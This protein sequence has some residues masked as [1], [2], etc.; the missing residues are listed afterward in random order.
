MVFTNEISF[1]HYE[2]TNFVD[3]TSEKT[4]D[5]RAWPRPTQVLMEAG[6]ACITMYHIPHSS[7]R[8]EHGTESRKNII[9]RIRN[10]KRQPNIVADNTGVT[11][12]PDRGFMGGWLAFEEGNNPWERS[13]HSMCNMWDEWEGMQD[14]VAEMK[15]KAS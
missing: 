15:S 9:F 1:V 5:G 3:E 8:N 10:K 7:T 6:D 12:H 13:K 11:D 14:I 4:P 2:K